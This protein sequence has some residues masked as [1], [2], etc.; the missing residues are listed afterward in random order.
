ML[1]AVAS[2]KG[3]RSHSSV[4]F[5]LAKGGPYKEIRDGW[6]EQPGSGLKMESGDA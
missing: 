3:K 1:A 6:P 4:L 2:K 5:V